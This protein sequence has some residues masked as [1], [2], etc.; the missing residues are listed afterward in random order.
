MDGFGFLFHPCTEFAQFGGHGGDAVGFFHAPRA[1]IAQAATRA[2]SKGHHGQGHCRIGDVVGIQIEGADALAGAA[3]YLNIIF[4]PLHGGADFFQLGGKR[5]VALDAVPPDAVH[6]HG[7]GG[8]QTGGK[9]I[10]CAGG[11]AFHMKGSRG[12]VTG[13]FR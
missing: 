11:I 1:D 2:G 6:A 4:A 9:E 3:G 7:S 5:G 8:E 12:V 13:C 10:G